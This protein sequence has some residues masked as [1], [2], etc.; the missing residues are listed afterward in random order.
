MGRLE[1]K[2]GRIMCA[3]QLGKPDRIPF[4]SSGS[5]LNAALTGVK[6]S[7]YCI[8]MDINL[9]ANLEGINMY[10]DPDGVQVTIFD[11]QALSTLWLGKVEIPGKDLPENDL[12]QM[13][14]AENMTQEDY[15]KILENGFAPWYQE[16]LVTKAG[17]PDLTNLMTHMGPAIGAFM[18]A[19]LPCVCGGNLYGP[20]EL[21]C[22]GRTLMNFFADDLMEIPDKVEKAM[23]LAQ[24]FNMANWRAQFSDPSTRPIA[25]WVGGWRGTPDLLSPEMFRRF[26]WRYLREVAEMCLEYGVIPLFH[27]DSDWTNGLEAFREMPKGSCILALDGKTDIFNAKKVIGDHCCIMGDVPAQLLSFGTPEEVD[28]YCKKLI[29]EVGPEGFILSSGCDAPYNAK[30]ENLKAM[31]DSVYKYTI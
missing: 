3:V 4:V 5:A 29:Y 2:I 10:C 11:P 22:G 17:N 9:K 30:L 7:D 24:E 27:L 13:H 1:E 19:G 18:Q 21:F 31:A 20:I 16:I 6:L 12:W 25:V 28:A 23:D 8:D 14:E 15:D 26:S